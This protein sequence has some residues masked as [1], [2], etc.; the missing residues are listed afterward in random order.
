MD[1]NKDGTQKQNMT[2]QNEKNDI[3]KNKYFPADGPRLFHIM[4]EKSNTNGKPTNNDNKV[5]KVVIN[6]TKTVS[7][8]E[9]DGGLHRF[10][11]VTILSMALQYS[12]IVTVNQTSH[13][14]Y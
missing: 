14:T 1:E 10:Y 3:D 4:H 2:K 8:R 11:M 12:V 13:E 5:S 6:H 7:G 9:G